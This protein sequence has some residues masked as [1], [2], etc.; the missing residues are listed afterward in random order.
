MEIFVI[1]LVLNT[2]VIYIF[3]KLLKMYYLNIEPNAS[4]ICVDCDSSCEIG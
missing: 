3:T 2:N 4:N 1:L